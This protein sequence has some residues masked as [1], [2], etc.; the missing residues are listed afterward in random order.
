MWLALL[1]L[2]FIL[3][4][5]SSE[6]FKGLLSIIQLAM[7][8]LVL[9][10]SSVSVSYVFFMTHIIFYNIQKC[11]LLKKSQSMPSFKIRMFLYYHS[12]QNISIKTAWSLSVLKALRPY[13]CRKIFN[14]LEQLIMRCFGWTVSSSLS[15]DWLLFPEN[16]PIITFWKIKT[17]HSINQMHQCVPSLLFLRSKGKNYAI[18]ILPPNMTKMPH[19]L[20]SPLLC[21]P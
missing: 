5:G 12:W 19:F 17:T 14:H 16:I 8:P 4:N 13:H 1:L 20:G 3:R 11:T 15:T 7:A 10:P 9:K 18:C 21:F 2:F 6:R